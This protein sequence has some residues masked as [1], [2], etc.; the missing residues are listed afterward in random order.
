MK[1]VSV[2]AAIA[3]LGAVSPAEAQLCSGAPSFAQAPYQVGVGA[4]FRDGAQ[5]FGGQFAAGGT[6]LFAGA[7]VAVLS[8]SDLDATQTNINIFAGT[9]LGVD[10]NDS[11]FFCPLASFGFGVGPDIGPVDVSTFS[12]R[13]GGSVGVIASSTDML[14]VVPTFGF[15]AAWQRVT[16]EAGGM[17]TDESDSYGVANLG[18]GF[19]FNRLVAIT[20][21]ISIPFSVA[22]SDVT[23]TIG[24]A[25]NFGQ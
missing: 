19:I 6:A 20:P 25:F 16:V 23:F 8:F 7:G 14:M 12:L 18:V 10:E 4:A 15:A 1:L 24:F 11:V 22:D 9:D 3:L 2:C 5:G 13:G 17:D 21:G